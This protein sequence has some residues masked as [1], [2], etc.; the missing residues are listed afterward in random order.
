M[1]FFNSETIAMGQDVPAVDQPQPPIQVA[2]VNRA[3][4]GGQAAAAKWVK[5]IFSFDI[6]LK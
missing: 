1:S 6:V 2:D 4:Q 5:Y 3:I